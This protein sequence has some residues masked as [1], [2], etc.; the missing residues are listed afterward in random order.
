M[1][2]RM[3]KV[4]LTSDV[5]GNDDSLLLVLE[6]SE[7]VLISLESLSVDVRLA[8][9][10]EVD[11]LGLADGVEESA[12]VD[13]PETEV[14]KIEFPSLEVD[15][16][17]LGIELAVELDRVEMDE[18][19]KLTLDS[20][21]IDWVGENVSELYVGPVAVESL[22]L[23]D[24]RLPWSEDVVAEADTL[25]A[26]EKDAVELVID[27]PWSELEAVEAVDDGVEELVFVS[28][29]LISV[30]ACDE[31]VLSSLVGGEEFDHRS[32]ELWR[33]AVWGFTLGEEPILA[34]SRELVKSEE[35]VELDESAGAML[36]R[37]ADDEETKSG[38]GILAI[39]VSVE[40]WGVEESET[41]TIPVTLV[42]TSVGELDVP[43]IALGVSLLDILSVF[44][45][46]E[47]DIRDLKGTLAEDGS[48]LSMELEIVE[49]AVVVVKGKGEEEAPEL[50][51]EIK[52][53]LEVVLLSVIAIEF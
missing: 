1:F 46:I 49:V 8:D 11:E 4:I 9:R 35:Y 52:D 31:I 12:D 7:L 23:A 41:V 39:L 22:E 6:V 44:D 24:G 20:T 18:A 10:S 50:S 42:E 28:V 26:A 29:K 2:G 48:P 45:D 34:E 14:A 53:G 47:L 15:E 30:E 17:P 5:V 36:E 27:E 19:V 38:L 3:M 13:K 25:D 21:V 33:K 43:A 32:L 51:G 16:T 40:L 37:L